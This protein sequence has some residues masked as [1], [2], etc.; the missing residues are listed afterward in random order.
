ML[1]TQIW[2]W[3]SGLSTEPRPSWCCCYVAGSSW[4]FWGDLAMHRHI[5]I[6]F[7]PARYLC[8]TLLLFIRSIQV[9]EGHN[10][11]FPEPSLLQAHSVSPYL[12]SLLLICF[13]SFQSVTVMLLCQFSVLTSLLSLSFTHRK[14]QFLPFLL[15]LLPSPI[16]SF[17][18][19][20]NGTILVQV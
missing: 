19:R 8:M 6:A 18:L 14:H 10:E 11:F 9:L 16:P 5:P 1:W 15:S 7:S 12:T 4:C 2:V 20:N 13:S 3:T 17:A